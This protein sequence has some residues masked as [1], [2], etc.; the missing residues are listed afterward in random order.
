[1]KL[2][3]SPAASWSKSSSSLSSGGKI[4]PKPG[5]IRC[6]SPKNRAETGQN[7]AKTLEIAPK[8]MKTEPPRHVIHLFLFLLLL[9]AAAARV[10]LL[11][12]RL[13]ERLDVARGTATLLP[14]N[15]NHRIDRIK[16]QYSPWL[17][18]VIIIHTSDNSTTNWRNA[19][20]SNNS[21]MV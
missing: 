16:S 9:L 11:L 15:I 18:I 20:N 21:I 12:H 7:Q 13:D 1:M 19:R 5:E 4:S 6:E 8:T 17:L 10:L 3:R 14:M 2:M